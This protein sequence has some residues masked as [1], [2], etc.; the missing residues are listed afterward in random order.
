MQYSV[1]DENG[2]ESHAYYTPEQLGEAGEK[3]Y[4]DLQKFIR[5]STSDIFISPLD[6]II[7]RLHEKGFKVGELTGRNSYVERDG[8]GNVVV[9]SLIHI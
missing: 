5:E 6:A 1:K 9:L 2:K 8:N 7:E 4:Y 3:A